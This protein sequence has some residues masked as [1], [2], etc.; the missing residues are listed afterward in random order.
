MES[1]RK[2]V[3]CAFGVLK[4]RFRFLKLPIQFHDK[5][6]ID[7]MFLT[8]VGLHNM[9]HLWDGRG[10]WEMGVMIFPSLPCP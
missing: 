10:E 9:L 1:V 7:D 8:C 4:G 2:D 6:V 3:E 5:E